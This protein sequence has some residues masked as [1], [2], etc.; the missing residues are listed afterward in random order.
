MGLTESAVPRVSSPAVPTAAP[1]VTSRR[2]RGRRARRPRLISTPSSTTSL[3][4]EAWSSLRVPV[5]GVPP[6]RDGSWARRPA[7]CD[8]RRRQPPVTRIAGRGSGCRDPGNGHQ[9]RTGKRPGAVST[10]VAPKSRR[11]VVR[12]EIPTVTNARPA[13]ISCSHRVAVGFA[14]A[15]TSRRTPASCCERMKTAVRLPVASCAYRWQN[16]PRAAGMIRRRIRREAT[17]GSSPISRSAS[18]NPQ[19]RSSC[20]IGPATVLCG[21]CGKQIEVDPRRI[22]IGLGPHQAIRREADSPK[23]APTRSGNRSALL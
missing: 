15:S 5:A 18:T 16:Q 3:V 12:C 22:R 10:A 8:H 20:V 2:V 23:D 1:A 11:E 13:P 7:A 17:S 19:A 6:L 14:R 21:E 9:R 4:Q